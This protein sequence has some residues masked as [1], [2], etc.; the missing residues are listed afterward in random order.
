MKYTAAIIAFIEAGRG[1]IVE[2]GP[3]TGND[4]YDSDSLIGVKNGVP[5]S[6]DELV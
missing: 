3:W 2:D 4:W 6:E 5:Y 1:A